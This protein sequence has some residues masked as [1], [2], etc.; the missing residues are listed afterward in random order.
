MYK[1]PVRIMR[2]ARVDSDRVRL[3]RRNFYLT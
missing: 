1:G 3:V 2:L